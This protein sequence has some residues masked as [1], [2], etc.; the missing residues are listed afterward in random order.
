MGAGSAVV[1]GKG[2]LLGWGQVQLGQCNS[3]PRAIERL[4]SCRQVVTLTGELGI[5]SSQLLGG[6]FSGEWTR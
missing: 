3:C 2:D 5:K 1:C 4:C 6:D